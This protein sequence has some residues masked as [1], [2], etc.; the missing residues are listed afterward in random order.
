LYQRGKGSG[1]TNFDL[2]LSDCTLASLVNVV[3]QA[4]ITGRRPKRYG[5]AHPNIVPYELFA[6]EDGYLVLG[7]G[8]DRQWRRFCQAVGR[9]DWAADPRFRTNPLRVEHRN[10]LIPV[11]RQFLSGRKTEHWLALLASSGVPHAPVLEVDQV[12]A[13]P[14]TAARQ[15]IAPV[16]DIDGHHYPILATP[17][18]WPGRSPQT[19]K[20]PPALG[21][22]SAEILRHWLDMSAEQIEALRATGAIECHIPPRAS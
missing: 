18:H 3:Q 7:I 2:A 10:E 19:I 15:M 22:H 21:Q 20:A 13:S 5:N 1:G 9:S 17:V 11:M 6:C 4:L 8:N 14:Q 16:E 12:L